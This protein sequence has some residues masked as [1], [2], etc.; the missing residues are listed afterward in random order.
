LFFFFG[1]GSSSGDKVNPKS[2]FTSPFS[3]PNEARRDPK[4]RLHA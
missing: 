1:S 4:V 3:C 2:R